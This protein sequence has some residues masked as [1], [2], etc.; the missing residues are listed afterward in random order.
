MQ[1]HVNSFQR[2]VRWPLSAMKELGLERGSTKRRI[3]HVP[4]GKYE[5]A[6][7]MVSFR[8]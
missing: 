2:R 4:Q 7:E 6:C 8:D 3:N 5:F 1:E